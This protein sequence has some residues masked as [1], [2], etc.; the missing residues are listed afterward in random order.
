MIRC[1]LWVHSSPQQVVFLLVA[2]KLLWLTGREAFG[3]TTVSNLMVMMNAIMDN[4]RAFG[5]CPGASCSLK[6]HS[7]ITKLPPHIRFGA[8]SAPEYFLSFLFFYLASFFFF[9]SCNR[10]YPLLIFFFAI[11]K[12]RRTDLSEMVD[13]PCL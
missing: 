3:R 2:R 5:Y 6:F 12:I 13:R 7:S 4:W 1:S 10:P 8:P 9:L 11:G